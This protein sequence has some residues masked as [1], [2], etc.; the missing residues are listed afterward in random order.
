V[1]GCSG[2]RL[3]IVTT[4]RSKS[5]QR[6]AGEHEQ[7]QLALVVT[8]WFHPFMQ[9]IYE[10]YP[11]PCPSWDRADVR[12]RFWRSMHA[13]TPP[14]YKDS[15]DPLNPPHPLGMGAGSNRVCA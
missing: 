6:R 9:P 14:C 5:I 3:L 1:E 11:T 2:A 7:T 13:S 15:Q 10:Y 12:N 4:T 8:G